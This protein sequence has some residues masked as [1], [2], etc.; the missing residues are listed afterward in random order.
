[1]I[2]TRL[3]ISLV[4]SIWDQLLVLERPLTAGFGGFTKTLFSSKMQLEVKQNPSVFFIQLSLSYYWDSRPVK[5][6]QD[7]RASRPRKYETK[8]YPMEA[9]QDW[10]QVLCRLATTLTVMNQWRFNHLSLWLKKLQR[11]KAFHFV[12]RYL[13]T[14]IRVENIKNLSYGKYCWD[15]LNITVIWFRVPE[16]LLLYCINQSNLIYL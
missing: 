10:P 1:M 15:V 3:K 4:S 16:L 13:H 11:V 2:L 6:R 5:T 7:Q 12:N 14:K 8:Y 9:R